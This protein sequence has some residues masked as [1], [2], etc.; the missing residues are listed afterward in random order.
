MGRRAA[1]P[2][3]VTE[4]QKIYFLKYQQLAART[5]Q[6]ITKAHGIIKQEVR[7]PVRPPRIGVFL[8]YFEN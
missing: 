2:S 3:F 8:W 1:Q 7:T 5:G 6:G 4:T